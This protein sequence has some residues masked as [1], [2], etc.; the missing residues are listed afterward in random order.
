LTSSDVVPGWLKN[1]FW[2]VP[3]PGNQAA[4]CAMRVD[5]KWLTLCAPCAVGIQLPVGPQELPTS[6]SMLSVARGDLYAN[7]N[8][9]LRS[10][11]DVPLSGGYF[12][13][14]RPGMGI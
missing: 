6:P 3:L 2:Q 7:R 8:R 11:V 10:V 4:A 13:H 14:G 9:L 5:G 12:D 1:W